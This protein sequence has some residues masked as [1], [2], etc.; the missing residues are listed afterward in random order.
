MEMT[1]EV[2][3]LRN[4][5]F[6]TFQ[7]FPTFNRFAPFHLASPTRPYPGSNRLN[8]ST[9]ALR[10][11]PFGRSRLQV[12][13][14]TTKS[15]SGRS[16]RSNHSIASLRLPSIRNAGPGWRSN[17]LR[18]P[19][20]AEVY[21]VHV[22][23]LR[24]ESLA[25]RVKYFF[26]GKE[27]GAGNA[28]QK[29]HVFHPSAAIL[30]W[31]RARSADADRVLYAGLGLSNFLD[32][33]LVP[34]IVLL[35]IVEVI[36]EDHP[37]SGDNLIQLHSRLILNVVKPVRARHAVVRLLNN[38]C[39][40]RRIVPAQGFLNHPVQPFERHV[41]WDQYPAPDRRADVDE[42]N[43]KLVNLCLV[44]FLHDA[45]F[46]LCYISAINRGLLAIRGQP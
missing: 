32:D 30:G 37:G 24:I 4:L 34:P 3:A 8:R 17:G 22:E 41:A 45:V 6:K 43:A 39:M 38:E 31:T 36:L 35:V 13:G 27:P 7:S 33:D 44:D 2:T 11:M 15:S 28:L 40:Q 29:F 21:S 9:A 1:R 12:Q 10:S 26:G 20:Q 23:C 14:S 5:P 25:D 16:S 42:S 18:D 19:S 46:H